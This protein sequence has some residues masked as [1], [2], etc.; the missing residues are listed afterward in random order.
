MQPFHLVMGS[1]NPCEVSRS[2]GSCVICAGS[3]VYCERVPVYGIV[4]GLFGI[5][6]TKLAAMK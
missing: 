4:T 1:F 2:G 6:L 5:L 3:A